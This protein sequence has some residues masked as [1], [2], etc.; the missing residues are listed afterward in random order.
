MPKHLLP[1]FCMLLLFGC[2]K[3]PELDS[4][5][6]QLVNDELVVFA[7]P[8]PQALNDLYE[9]S[10]VLIFGETHYVQEHQDFVVSQLQALSDAGYR[11]IFEELFH[12]FSWMVEDYVNGDIAQLPEFILY[13]NETLIEGVKQFNSTADPTRKFKFAY[14]DVNHWTDNFLTSLEEIENVIGGHPE[15]SSIKNSQPDS[16]S[17]QSDLESL[18]GQLETDSQTYIS[19]WGQEWFDRILEIID[20]EIASSEYR[21]NRSD[22]WRESVMFDNIN[23][24][25]Q[26]SG[27]DKI[28]VNAGF[29]HGQKETYMGTFIDRLGKRLDDEVNTNSIAFIGIKGERKLTFNDTNSFSFDLS[30][31]SDTDDIVREI[32]R[33][34]GTSISYLPLSDSRFSS[35]NVKMSY[36]F[37][38]FVTAP[39]GRQFDAIITYPEISV[40]TSMDVYDWN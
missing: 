19:L 12:S 3:D 38:S 20:V 11:V 29:F 18:K 36:T 6:K 10:S 4:E 24:V 31:D 8:T 30:K 14:M 17:Y 23:R 2:S 35:K 13:F 9:N 25:L 26:S 34:A 37:G 40:L 21:I 16:Q 7:D 1:I 5:I 28:L 39:I 22:D 32:N 15:F 27:N 33:I